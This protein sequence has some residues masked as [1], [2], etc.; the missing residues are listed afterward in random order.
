MI[1]VGIDWDNTG[2]V[3]RIVDKEGKDIVSTLRIKRSQ[4]GF[5]ELIKEVNRHSEGTED[6]LIGIERDKDVIVDYLLGLGYKVYLINPNAM[7]SFRKR[8][9]NS[10]QKTDGFDAYVIA[11]VVRTDRDILKLIK[12]KSEKV[13]R[14]EFLVRQRDT[15]VRD[16]TRLINRLEAMLKEYYPVFLGFFEDVGCS[17]SVAFLQAYPTLDMAKALTKEEIREFLRKKSVYS[18]ESVEKIWNALQKQQIRIDKVVIESRSKAVVSLCKHIEL[19]NEEIKGY[20]KEMEKIIEEDDDGKIF[21]SLPGAGSI[22]SSELFMILGDDRER[23]K[24]AREVMALSGIV[25][26]T[27]RSGNYIYRGFRFRC[28]H[29]YRNIFTRFAYTSLIKSSWA[30]LYYNKKRREGKTHYHALRCL[31]TLWIKVIYALWREKE[32]YNEDKHLASITRHKM[33]NR[34]AMAVS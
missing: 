31:A 17:T 2:Y 12:G 8:Y 6:V 18:Q 3:V 27:K 26:V 34:L 10:E 28:N 32:M 13:R 29:F 5:G 16:R 7:N 33:K 30:R 9:S 15:A 25:P 4:K 1:F 20:K 22:I 23:Y 19:L 14:I 11:N 24:D 21:K